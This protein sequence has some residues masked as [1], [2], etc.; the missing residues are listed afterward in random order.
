[1]FDVSGVIATITFTMF[2]HILCWMLQ[3]LLRLFKMLHFVA[4][5]G[6]SKVQ[7]LMLTGQSSD[8]KLAHISLSYRQQLRIL[9]DAGQEEN[10]Q[11][12]ARCQLTLLCKYWRIAICVRQYVGPSLKAIEETVRWC[13]GWHLLANSEILLRTLRD[14]IKRNH[15]HYSQLLWNVNPP[16]AKNIIEC[17]ICVYNRKFSLCIIRCGGTKRAHTHRLNGPLHMNK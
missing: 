7:V 13:L 2:C 10:T 11:S 14:Q 6:C 15:P 12:L 9:I 8:C 17:I 1:M 5:V 16:F 3:T 4:G